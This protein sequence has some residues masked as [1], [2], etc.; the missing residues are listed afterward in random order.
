MRM[1]SFVMI[2]ELS[3]V[4]I[5]ICCFPLSLHSLEEG[6]AS[7]FCILAWRIPWTRSL[8]GY[9]PQRSKKSDKTEHA[10]THGAGVLCFECVFSFSP[11]KAMRQT[12]C[13]SLFYRFGSW[14]LEKSSNLP[15]TVLWW[16]VVL[17]RLCLLL[18]ILEAIRQ[19]LARRAV[20]AG[21]S[22][23]QAPVLSNI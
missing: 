14:G 6:M 9:S 20:S 16:K 11:Y 19:W 10:C 13:L 2:V 5:F 1:H 18:T 12:L 8:E 7:H 22:V 15:N 4:L 17:S 23:N 21:R 3:G